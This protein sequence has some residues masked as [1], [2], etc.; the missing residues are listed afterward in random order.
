[1]NII[2]NKTHSDSDSDQISGMFQNL[3]CPSKIV[4]RPRVTYLDSF[5]FFHY[6]RSDMRIFILNGKW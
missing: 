3:E 2:G 5:S 6:F 4:W 1:M